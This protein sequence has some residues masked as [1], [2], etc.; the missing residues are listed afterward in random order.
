MTVHDKPNSEIY[1]NNSHLT[2][3]SASQIRLQFTYC[4]ALGCHSKKRAITCFHSKYAK[5]PFPAKV[6]L[7]ERTKY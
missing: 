5:P 1:I 3:D 4:I 2:T 7:Y 6:I